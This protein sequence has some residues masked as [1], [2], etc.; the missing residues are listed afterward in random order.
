MPLF[1]SPP[2]EKR[3]ILRVMGKPALVKHLS[4]LGLV[5]G[6]E[7]SL[8]QSLSGNVILEVK[9]TRLALDQALAAKVIV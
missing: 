8:V 1:L 9:Q 5:V 7:V 6:A 4:D 2:G 3:K